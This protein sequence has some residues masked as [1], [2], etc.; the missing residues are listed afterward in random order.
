MI[1]I[2]IF[3]SF[4]KVLIIKRIHKIHKIRISPLL[5]CNH[6]LA[7]LDKFHFHCFRTISPLSFWPHRIIFIVDILQSTVR[8]GDTELCKIQYHPPPL[9][10]PVI[11]QRSSVL[12]K[13]FFVKR[14]Q[15]LYYFIRSRVIF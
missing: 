9:E 5:I 3:S 15:I 10:D 12:S 14:Y 2:L 13:T 1:A 4:L 8:G 11:H 6:N 7:P